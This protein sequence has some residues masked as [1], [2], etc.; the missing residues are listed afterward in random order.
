MR[1]LG[2]A[3][4]VL[5]TLM[6]ACFVWAADVDWKLYGSNSVQGASFCFYDAKGITRTSDRHLRVWVKCLLQKDLDGVDLKDELNKKIIERTAQKVVDGYIPPIA[7]VEDAN[8]DQAMTVIQY[9][10]TANLGNVRDHAQ[11]LYELNC[12]ERMI[13][14]LSSLVRDANGR[15]G[16]SDEASDW[17]HVAPEGSA[18]TLLK[19]LCR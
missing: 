1:A 19:I 15:E 16:F 11:F 17:K 12:S 7:I 13:R 18:A 14:W 6:F 5:F 10:E 8:F 9:E 3:A 2:F 4:T